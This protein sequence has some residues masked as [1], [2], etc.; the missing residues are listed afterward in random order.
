MAEFKE[1]SLVDAVL[2]FDVA[3]NGQ[4][5]ALTLHF[6]SNTAVRLPTTAPVAMRIWAAIDKARQAHGWSVPTT[7]VSSDR[8]Q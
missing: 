5:A 2:S 7:P 4:D 6:D 8:L 1:S 3:S